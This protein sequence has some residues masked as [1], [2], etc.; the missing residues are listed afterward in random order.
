MSY[1]A[2]TAWLLISAP[3]DVPREHLETVRSAISRW[4]VHYGRTFQATIVP[5]AWTDHAVAAFGDRPQG[6]LNQQLVNQ[7]DMGIALFRDRLGTVTGVAPSGT[8]EEVQRLA[9]E[10]KAVGILRDRTPRPSPSRAQAEEII[11]LEEHFETSAYDRALI[12]SF[13]NG[14]QLA[15]HVDAFINRAMS[16]LQ[17]RVDDDLTSRQYFETVT[18]AGERPSPPSEGDMGASA[19]EDPSRGV[20][21]RVESTERPE[22][23]SSGRLRTKRNWYLVLSNQTRGPLRNVRYEYVLEDG[24]V[25]DLQRQQE[26]IRVMPPGGEARLPML[27]TMGSRS[28][29]ECRVTWE[30][31]TGEHVTEATVVT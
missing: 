19:A 8:W 11:R 2:L 27:L 16:Q 7:A 26:P 10:G 9:A 24:A 5:V 15:N 1:R 22:T 3:S 20:W 4:N 6:L 12:L 23:D 28:Q 30:D 13:E 18:A 17:Q 31:Q 25:F 14:A 29:A 21:P